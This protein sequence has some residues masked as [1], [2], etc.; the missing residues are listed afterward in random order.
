MRNVPCVVKAALTAKNKLPSKEQEFP[1]A[2]G[3]PG[4]KVWEK[5]TTTAN[6]G[7]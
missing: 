6:S 4:A 7:T 2:G 3:P 5:N 1:G